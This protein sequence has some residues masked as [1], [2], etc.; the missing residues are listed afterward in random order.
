MVDSHVLDACPLNEMKEINIENIPLENDE[1][2][3]NMNEKELNQRFER[4]KAELDQLPDIEAKLKLATSFME[5]SLAQDKVPDFKCFWEARKTCLDLFKEGMSPQLRAFFWARYHELSQEARRLKD[6]LDEESNFAVEQIEIAIASLEKEIEGLENSV[7][8]TPDIDYLESCHLL[9]ENFDFYNSIQ[10]ELNLLNL[11]AARINALRKELIKTEMRIRVKNKFFQRLSKVGDLIFP[12]RKELIQN[13]SQKFSEGV[14]AFI[15]THTSHIGEKES[16]YQL[17]EEIKALQSAAKHI[18]LNTLI[19]NQT[20]ISLSEF[21]D[22]LKILEKEKKKEIAQKR[23]LFKKNFQE[24]NQEL[25]EVSQRFHLSELNLAEVNKAIDVIVAKM[26][27]AV[28]GRD[29]VRELKIELSKLREKIQE[30][31]QAQN[32]EK[33]RLESERNRL[34]K[35]LIRELSSKAQALLTSSENS[36]YD[37]LIERRDEFLTE[38]EKAA[39]SKVEKSELE[40]ELRPLKDLLTAKKEQALMDLPEDKRQALSQLKELLKQRRE[41]RQQVKD[42]LEHLRKAA[43]GTSGL[44]FN[45]GLQLNEEMAQEKAQLEAANVG[46]KEIEDK[47]KELET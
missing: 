15:T 12:K 9:K 18:T 35:D 33:T 17:R 40:K 31:L 25:V 46:V 14:A 29:E 44:D 36:S 21:W 5:E 19:F 4:F 41:R 43:K 7:V 13:I 34:K 28:L 20:R 3:S 2:F 47:I 6:L 45:K 39:L 38:I 10:K 16:I 32:D 24:I 42:H 27:A 11:Y 1:L 23:E 30:K 26:R 37:G 8:Q 22:K